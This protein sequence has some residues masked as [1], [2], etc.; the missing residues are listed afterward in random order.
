[1][2]VKADFGFKMRVIHRYLGF[3]LAGIM[4]VYS[5][6]GIVLI[7]RDTDFLKQEKI[8]TK[9]I[10][11]NVSGEEIGQKL[12]VRNFSIEKEEGN[13]VYFGNGTYDKSTGEANI[14]VKSLPYVLDKMTHMHKAKS[15]DAL[16][17][18]NI[19]FGLSLFFF[20]IS[21]FWM[22]MPKTSVFKKGMYF[23]A[24]GVVLTLIL[25]FI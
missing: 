9:S 1:M 19:F 21:S 13:L 24:G 5:L 15:G 11:T 14:T 23:T 10:E 17:F 18:L 2:A 4:A 6:S 7:F 12:G 8:I 3:F 22:F 25:L 20:V 16:F